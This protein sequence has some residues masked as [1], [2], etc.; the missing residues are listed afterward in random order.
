[1][2]EPVSDG[3]VRQ[4]CGEALQAARFLTRLPLPGEEGGALAAAAWAFP[5]VGMVVALIGG[6]LFAIALW[7]DVPVPLAA[8]LA[9]AA[10]VLATGGLHEDG[11]ADSA[12]G[13]GGRDAAARLAIMRDSRSGAYGILAL[14]FSVGLRAAALAAIAQPGPVFAAL[15]AAHAVG[16]GALPPVLRWATPA[17]PDGLGASAG[18]PEP[19][20]VGWSVG[21]AAIGAV[22]ALGFRPGLSALLIA[23]VAMALLGGLA[24]RL[25]GG[26]TG[27]VLGAI[28]QTG[29]IAVLIVAAS[30]LA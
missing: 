21:L 2:R 28:E 12:D 22:A 26:Y 4:R 19:A 20:I 10:T 11:L 5:L 17:R 1:M 16:R 25:V 30:W 3:A 9:V 15:I 24:I 7:L 13:L 29:E 27:D 8:L 14:L 18:R 23:G 6:C